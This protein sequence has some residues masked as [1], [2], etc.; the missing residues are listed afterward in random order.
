MNEHLFELLERTLRTGGPGAAFDVLI[1]EALEQKNYSLLFEARLMQKR[2]ALGLSLIQ[3]ATISDLPAEH[4][5]AY[6]AS[7]VEAARETGNL[8]LADGQI[9]RAWQYF[10]AIG[11]PA[12][13]TAAIE[14]FQSGEGIERVIEI[15][16][17]EGVNPRK[18]FELL[19]KQRGTC[20]A[21]DFAMQYMDRENRAAFLQVLVRSM[22]QE[23]A[24]HLKETIAGVEGQAPQSSDVAELIAGRDWLFDGGHY[25]VE[26]SHLASIVQ[27]SPEFEDRETQRLALHMADYGRRLAPMF[28][29]PGNPPF[30]D[31]YLDHAQYLRALLGEEAEAG[32]AHFRKKVTASVR[33]AADVLVGLLSR[34]GR[35]GEAIQISV[36]HLR[37]AA[38][39]G[40][41]SAIQLCQMAGDYKQLRHL[42]REQGDLLAFTAGILAG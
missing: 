21:I 23:L 5:A 11:D 24:A 12:P 17:H 36:E 2:H 6:E 10:R 3:T 22:Y 34:L 39:N 18:G 13:V 32:I 40:C 35:Y 31:L 25:Y 7:M 33:G 41:P 16:L 14:N 4:Q 19:L 20:Q 30:E 37:G 1:R 28:H 38:G 26:N 29:F 15:A 9:A 42:A 8:F 27:V